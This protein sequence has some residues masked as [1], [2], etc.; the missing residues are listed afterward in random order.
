MARMGSFLGREADEGLLAVRDCDD[1]ITAQPFS[2]GD[3]RFMASPLSKPHYYN[4]YGPPSYVTVIP[5][6]GCATH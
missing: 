2:V 5:G 1:T 4:H 3:D 6:S